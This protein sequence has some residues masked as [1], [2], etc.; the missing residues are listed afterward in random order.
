MDWPTILSL[1]STLA[2]VGAV[3]FAGLQ[4]R[5]N[6]EQ[7]REQA[8]IELVRS[9][10]SVEWTS[11]VGPISRLP[12]HGTP[13]L[14]ASQAEAATTLALRLEAMGYLVYR[15]AVSL[16][17]VDELVGGMSRTAWDRLEP[18]VAKYRDGS[19]NQKAF[20][21]FQWLAER[22]AERSV[23]PTP[24]YEAYRDWRA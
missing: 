6:N 24:A 12:L 4:V 16:D 11:S 23:S 21:W 10:Q 18:W 13:D 1:L 2:L 22:L 5:Q 7:R 19:G 20:E 3:V 9:M 8:A 17:L 14:T 15:R